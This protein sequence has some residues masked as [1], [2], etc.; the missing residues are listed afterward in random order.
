[1]WGL[2]IP[3]L[4]R[5]RNFFPKIAMTP[6]KFGVRIMPMISLEITARVAIK[7]KP[8]NYPV[9]FTPD[10]ALAL[11]LEQASQDP[12]EYLALPRTSTARPFDPGRPHVDDAAP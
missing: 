6:L 9:G 1:M 10:Q 5:K 3:E 7:F 11:E 4:N 8:E 2:L 12:H